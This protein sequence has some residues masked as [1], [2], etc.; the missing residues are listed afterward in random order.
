MIMTDTEVNT[1][2]KDK[3]EHCKSHRNLRD[4]MAPSHRQF[5][6]RNTHSHATR[7]HSHAIILAFLSGKWSFTM[8]TPQK[9]QK[10]CKKKPFPFPSSLIK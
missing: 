10:I 1:L 6:A 7:T 3:S 5:S 2:Q 9:A 8:S 4:S